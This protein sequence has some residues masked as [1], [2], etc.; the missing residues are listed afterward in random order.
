MATTPRRTLK[1][2]GATET[3]QQ[4]EEQLEPK[5][6]ATT[7]PESEVKIEDQTDPDLAQQL[8][9]T[10][11]QLAIALAKLESIE[12]QSSHATTA[13]RMRTV[14]GENGWTQEEY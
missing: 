7:E 9:D 13:V 14:L 6:T 1:T 5:D 8:A 3:T 10:Q 2:P 12:N 4:P 11:E